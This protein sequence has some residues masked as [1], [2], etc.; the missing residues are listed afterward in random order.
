MPQPSPRARASLCLVTAL[1]TCV[2]GC[3]APPRL[4]AADIAPSPSLAPAAPA[5]ASPQHALPLQFVENRGQFPDGVVFA[6]RSGGVRAEVAAD[7]VTLQL[8]GAPVLPQGAAHDAPRSASLV[9]RFVGASSE[10][11]LAGEGAPGSRVHLYHGASPEAWLTDIPAYDAVRWEQL[12]PGVDVVLR[13]AGGRLEYDLMLAPGARLSDVVMELDGAL[14]LSLGADGALLARTDVGTLAQDIP[15]T[16]QVLPDGTREPLDARFVL[17]GGQRFGF[18]APGRHPERALVLDPG[19]TY[20]S[21]LGGSNWDHVNAIARGAGNSVYLAGYTTS[22]NFPNTPGS[23]QQALAGYGDAF[24]AR[25][26]LSTGALSW[27]T[28]L[29]GADSVIFVEE[30]ARALAVDAG[31]AAWI[32]G[33]AN[34]PDFPVTPGA[35]QPVLAGGS[36]AFV[37][38]L[39]AD[40]TLALSTFLGGGKDDVATCLA[41]GSNGVFV[42]GRTASDGT[43]PFPTTAGAA[44]T[45]FNSIFFTTDVFVTKLPLGGGPPIWSTLLGGVLRDEALAIAVDA[46]GAATVTGLTGSNNFPTTAGAF[47][48][49]FNGSTANKLDAFVTRLSPTGSALTWSTYLGGAESDEA[50]SVALAADGGVCVAGV[51]ASID[52]P[53]SVGAAQTLFG[54]GPNDAFIARLSADGSALTWA[55]LLGGSGDDAANALAL[56]AA[57]QPTLAGETTS[58][59]FPVTSGSVG[60]GNAGGSDAFLARFSAD[61]AT[62]RSSGTFGGSGDDRAEALALDVHGAG[63]LAGETSSTN[64]PVTSGAFDATSNGGGDAFVARVSL[65]PWTDLGQGKAGTGG[66]LPLLVGT[67]SL[68]GGSPGAFT[69]SNARPNALMILF[70]GNAAGS[71]PLKGGTL[72]PFPFFFSL[73]LGTLADGSLPLGFAAWPTGLPAGLTL[74]FQEWIADPGATSG[75]SATNGLQAT[76]P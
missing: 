35:W 76:L 72:V 69:L 16:W 8:L 50:R 26:D 45:S 59:N 63:L 55:S 24:V 22:G 1:S 11:T 67:G 18:E 13:D 61:G 47:D 29:G 5:A 74:T 37:A 43:P 68:V 21:Y 39:N 70:V 12:Q 33:A 31:G 17:L 6:A 57:G 15:A 27:A 4:D 25:M 73:Q 2:A 58:E 14:D 56:D 7:G 71:V 20:S 32:A 65:P 48:T 23:S 44:D 53:A 66:K 62:L 3:Q 41:L 36:D 52:F 19:L 54:G 60:A 51:T 9:L 42:A 30:S 28:Y 75:A 64:L 10:A 46:A 38:K 40:G 49:S 34:S